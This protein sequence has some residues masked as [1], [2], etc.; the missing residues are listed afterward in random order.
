MG[1]DYWRIE[2]ATSNITKTPTTTMGKGIHKSKSEHFVEMNLR[3]IEGQQGVGLETPLWVN[4]RVADV[5]RLKFNSKMQ[6]L[7]SESFMQKSGARSC[8]SK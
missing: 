1:L 3:K 2:W 8:T 5:W 7:H 4:R 6:Q